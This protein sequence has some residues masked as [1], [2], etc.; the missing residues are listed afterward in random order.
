[1][2]LLAPGT[3]IGFSTEISKAY[4]TPDRSPQRPGH[5]FCLDR[6]GRG[7]PAE[8]RHA[9]GRRAHSGN[10]VRDESGATT[11]KLS[12]RLVSP[13]RERDDG[14][15]GR[16]TIGVVAGVS[17]TGRKS[18]MGKKKWHLC[19]VLFLLFVLFWSLD[20]HVMA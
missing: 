7:Y 12:R 6:T 13:R 9:R 15:A 16:S 14:P 8:S 11:T 20:N 3:G 4:C 1:M 2:N 19:L 17:V 5:C 10:V 18:E